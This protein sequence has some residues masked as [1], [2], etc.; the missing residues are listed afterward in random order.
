MITI[1]YNMPLPNKPGILVFL[2]L[3]EWV[4]GAQSGF[5]QPNDDT[6]PRFEVAS[7]KA[8]SERSGPPISA[9][10]ARLTARGQSL[11]SIISWAYDVQP[12]LLAGADVTHRYDIVATAGHPVPEQQMRLMLQ[13]LLIERFKLAI[14]H[15][16]RELNVRVLSRGQGPLRL[17]PSDDEEGP[18]EVVGN[19]DQRKFAFKGTMSEFA[20]GFHLLDRTG[21]PGRYGIVLEYSEY[22]NPA[23]PDTILTRLEAALAAIPKLGLK[24]ESKRLPLDMIVVDHAETVPVGN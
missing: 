8:S 13:E 23:G 3:G 7:V 1:L 6:T 17:R 14:H 18:P 9:A 11:E 24:I 22:L 2:F 20:S 21:L 15:E 4:S 12:L 5:A 16:T 10:H 19:G